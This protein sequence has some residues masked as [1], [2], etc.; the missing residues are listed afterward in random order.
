MTINLPGLGS[1]LD[2]TGIINQLVQI[3]S[4][5]IN[6]L[7]AKTSQI[8]SASQTF[9]SLSSKLST[10]KSAALALS[11]LVGFSSFSA[12]SGD[13]AVVASVTGAA[14]PG[15]FAVD[16]TQ[17]AREQRTYSDA[18]ASAGALGFSGT[19]GL[20]VGSGAA[21][22]VAVA[23]SDSL[24]DVA[25]H[26]S[27]SG[28]RVSASV[29]YDGTQYR[30]QVRGLDSGAAN[31]I[32]FTESGFSLGL[33]TP[34]N[35]FQAAQDAKLKVD[36]INVTRPTN[37][38]TGVVPGVT[39]A[40]TNTT[41]TPASVSV[42]TDTSALKQK[43]QSFVSAYNDF[44]Y[45]AHTASGFGTT[46][47]ANPVLAGDSAIRRALAGV[48]SI[49][50]SVVAGSTGAYS[51]LGSVGMKVMSDGTISFD[52]SKFDQAAAA[53]PVSVQRL[54]VTDASI[55]ATGVMKSLADTIDG[56]TI[57]S[58]SIFVSRIDGF[59]RRTKS[60]AD[61]RA[62]MATE[63]TSYQAMLQK[64]FAAM[65][66]VVGQYQTIGNAIASSIGSTS[67]K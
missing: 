22:S 31:A 60:L 61:Q 3:A 26:I 66:A 33:T 16:V 49:F 34:A 42:E 35:T 23:A 65:D 32:T 40:L 14:S 17:L 13:A 57:G 56:L 54:F 27:A 29:V 15:S 1:G 62:R 11:D 38:I 63:V 46:K 19:L 18:Q 36:G 20:R 24:A 44:V 6:T 21:V 45:T 53:D 12:S 55:G 47:A 39:L 67:T 10:V 28:A 7:D 43:I 37:Q 25:A 9:S 30:L 41:T 8:N 58:S 5:P 48:H 2:T 51:T 64:Q 52:G 59:G 4:Q 50:G